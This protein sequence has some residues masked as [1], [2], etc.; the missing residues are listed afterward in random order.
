MRVPRD[1]TLSDQGASFDSLGHAPQSSSLL[2][3][4]SRAVQ[5]TA[6]ASNHMTQPNYT[7]PAKAHSTLQDLTLALRLLCFGVYHQVHQTVWVTSLVKQV[8]IQESIGCDSNSWEKCWTGSWID[9]AE[10]THLQSK[11]KS[12]SFWPITC[13]EDQ[14]WSG[15]SMTTRIGS[16]AVSNSLGSRAK[17]LGNPY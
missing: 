8:T 3:E 17:R 7:V 5:E 12:Q 16:A 9:S 1:C 14:V 10:T 2:W 4:H 11:G 6:G 15:K 13:T